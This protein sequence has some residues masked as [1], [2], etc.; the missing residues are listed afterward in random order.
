M[1]RAIILAA[2]M[3]TRLGEY[4]KNLPKGM[5]EFKGQSLLGRQINTLRRNGI[6]EIVIVT[7]YKAGA[8]SFSGVEYCHNGRYDSTNMVE[9]LMSAQG[10]LDGDLLVCYAD[11]IVED[12]VMQKVIGSG[13]DV[14]VCVDVGWQDYWF[15]R[16]GRLDFDTE[17]LSLDTAGRIIELGVA[18]VQ[19]EAIDARYVGMIKFSPK[20]IKNCLAVYEMEKKS[21]KGGKWRNSK[22]FE[23]GYFTD[24][25]Q[26]M[27]EAG[28]TVEAI[29]ITNGWLEFDTISDYETYLSWLKEGS[30]ERFIRFP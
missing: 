18:D 3:G 2:G 28:N 26:A 10:F 6:N 13:C 29:E 23:N 5:L 11:I 1:N 19:P 4:T 27:I 21:Y 14:G 9:S 8:I 16:Y 22:S 17:S 30:I 25:I 12:S 7:G 20:G 15:A 24:L